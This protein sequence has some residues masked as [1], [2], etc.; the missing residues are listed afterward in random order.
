MPPLPLSLQKF[1]LPL[2][3]FA[4]IATSFFLQFNLNSL[5]LYLC[6][7]SIGK[8]YYWFVRFRISL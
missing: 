6:G 1:L 4:G 2:L 8:A 7:N 3:S 5:A